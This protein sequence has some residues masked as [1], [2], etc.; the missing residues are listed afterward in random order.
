MT[1]QT[2]LLTS[3]VLVALA[4]VFVRLFGFLR[5]VTLAATY[6]AGMVSDAFVIAFT[7]PG[8]V[9][10]LVGSSTAA[11]FIPAY[12]RVETD[13]ARFTSNIITL[14]AAIG[15]V[16]AAVF[17]FI[18]QTLT[19]LFASQLDDQTFALASS[20]IR[21]MV[22]TSVPVLLAGIL[23]PYLQIKNAFF[24]AAVINIPIN[25]AAIISI[26]L[27]KQ[28]EMTA[29]MGYGVVAGNIVMLLLFFAA[30]ARNGYV[31]RPVWE[32][33]APE[34]RVLLIM[35]VP[36]MIST[37]IADL[38]L[39]V[40][41][42]FASSLVSGS[43]SSLNYAS[44]TVNLMTGL[45][46]ISIATVLFPRMAELAAQDN[47]QEIR[48]YIAACFRKL[49][50]ILLP[51]TLG[52]ILL[53]HPIV[54]LMFERGGFSPEDTKRTAE[55][56]QMYAALLF[57]HSMNAIMIRALFS[58]R[59]TKTPA[60]ISA[61]GVA[62]SILLNFLLI[63]PLAH[64]GLALASSAAAFISLILL[65]MALRKRLGPLGL[66][67]ELKDW[68]K[69]LTATL[70]MGAV[71]YSGLILLP[72]MSGSTLQCVILTGGLVLAGAGIYLLLH[73]LLRT[74]FLRESLQLVRSFLHK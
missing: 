67:S 6:G 42:N 28:A 72:V 31:Y 45:I 56:L 36:V 5:E 10:A 62:V 4:T 32:P 49:I 13:K 24:L 30:A 52:I 35:L 53:A 27:S 68:V 17:T 43:I 51:A 15:L 59:D 21:I 11:V 1:K 34:L 23:Q 9:L 7:V 54:R 61:I 57:A 2:T 8:I 71:V 29:V 48:R 39:I 50:P 33:K 19:F 70:I 69:T 46:G 14:L 55:C 38:N 41:R 20:L 74:V 40:D 65:F 16:F 22:W 47:M 58:F 37:F 66:K 73:A 3:T 64:M 25:I 63:G 60:V 12:T 18:P 44:K 26:A